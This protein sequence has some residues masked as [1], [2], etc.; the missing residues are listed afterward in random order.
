MTGYTGIE[1]SS[2]CCRA[3]SARAGR[4]GARVRAFAVDAYHPGKALDRDATRRQ[5]A[6][7]GGLGRRAR[8]VL[9][10]VRSLHQLVPL[11]RGRGRR[12]RQEALDAATA[13]LFAAGWTRDAHVVLSRQ[14]VRDASGAR[15]DIVLVAAA[16]REDIESRLAPLVEAGFAIHAVTTPALALAALARGRPD[17]RPFS[18]TAYLALCRRGGALAIMRD[19][20]LLFAR[21]FFWSCQEEPASTR[22]RLLERY[23]FVTKLGPELQQAFETVR[24]NY[25]IPVDQIL[26]CG[27]MPDLRSLAMPLIEELDVEVETL[28]SLAGID[29]AALPEPAEGF[30]EQVAALRLACALAVAAPVNLR[31]RRLRDVVP[32]P[33]WFG[34]TDLSS[35]AAL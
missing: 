25:G 33:G 9:W 7:T 20:T 16:A 24:R 23:V 29:G 14:R 1:V 27:D 17:S 3:V 22:R 26:T 18:A 31:P 34:R 30:H 15:R 21:D 19:S 2:L 12:W 13:E 32:R 28:D 11:P 35:R 4:A 5:L 10:G 6:T 8:V